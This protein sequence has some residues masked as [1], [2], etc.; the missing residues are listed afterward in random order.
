MRDGYHGFAAEKDM[1]I[2]SKC[3]LITLEMIS[4]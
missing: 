3:R 1:N 4:T 2:S